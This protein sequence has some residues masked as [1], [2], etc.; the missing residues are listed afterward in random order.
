MVIHT[1]LDTMLDT[2]YEE[3]RKAWINLSI[4]VIKISKVLGVQ[5]VNLH[6]CHQRFGLLIKRYKK[7]ILDTSVAS[8]T[9]LIQVAKEYGI[10]I[11]IET[12]LY[13][14][15]LEHI[16]NAVPALGINL[17]VGH[18]FLFGGL[19]YIKKFVKTFGNKILHCHMHDNHGKQDEHL[20][21]GKGIIN[22]RKVVKW[23]REIDY[24]NT[25]TFEVFTTNAKVVT[26]EVNM[27]NKLQ[28]KKSM[29][30]IKKFWEQQ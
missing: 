27:K 8:L 5:I 16:I 10:K 24:G 26:N 18:S 1:P 23:L 21:V 19:S 20:P 17:D 28:A 7:Q 3:I 25:I 15:D 9:K 2:N 30:K 11:V 29:E 14:Q 4:E 6:A 22:Y 12:P 13:F